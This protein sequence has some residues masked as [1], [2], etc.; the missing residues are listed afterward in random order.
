MGS[1]IV[2]ILI[3]AVCAW[4]LFSFPIPQPFKNVL[5]GLLLI[6]LILIVANFFGFG[7]HL[8]K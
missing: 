3:L 8:M 4:V 5:F 2:T 1:L 7:P 6:C